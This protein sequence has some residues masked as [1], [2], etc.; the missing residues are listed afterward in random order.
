MS[1][2]ARRPF[3]VVDELRCSIVIPHYGDPHQTSRLVAELLDGTSMQ[4]SVEL[5]VVDDGSPDPLGPLHGAKV[6][7]SAENRGFGHAV[8]TG[9]RATR[10]E[11]V[12]VL[13]SDLRPS[14]D[15]VRDL[16]RAARPEFPA[17]TAPTITEGGVV[18]ENT[19]A[20]PRV[21]STVMSRSAVPVIRDR[22]PRRQAQIRTE[23]GNRAVGWVSGAAMCFPRTVFD[24]V[25][26]F[27]EDF[28][29]YLEDVDLQFRLKSMGIRR[30][31]LESVSVDHLGASSSSQDQRR[32]WLVDSTFVY[33][34]KRRQLS[35]LVVAW[36]T[37]I[38]SNLAY[39]L[40]RR[41]AGKDVDAWGTAARRWRMMIVGYGAGRAASGQ[42]R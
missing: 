20:F 4:G 37:M 33:F 17:L 38:A 25:G 36:I 16:V 14:P 39:D 35:I 13:N 2:V 18:M 21:W 6:I 40:A 41:A 23:H 31:L 34:R 28:F 9:V 26:G 32:K 5:V 11:V 30:V 22:A 7:R 24:S 8:N 1:R 42:R 10:G 15:F 12:L 29:M 27:D 3:V 19:T